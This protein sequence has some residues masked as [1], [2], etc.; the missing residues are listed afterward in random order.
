MGMHHDGLTSTRW[1]AATRGLLVMNHEYTDDG[2]LHPGGM[3]P[4]TAEKVAKSQAAHGISVCEIS[5]SCAG[6]GAPALQQVRAR[7]AT[8]GASPRVTPA[9]GP[10]RPGRRPPADAHRRR[11]RGP[12]RAGHH[13]QL[14]QRHDAL[15]HL[16]VGRRELGQ[17]YFHRPTNPPRTK[18]L[19]HAQERLVPLA[20]H[21][22]RFDTVRHPNEPNR[23]GWIVELDPMPTRHSTPV[24]RTALGRAAHEG[25]WVAVTKDG[26]A[27]VYS[28]EDARFEYIYKFVS[29]DRIAPGR[30]RQDRRAG[31]PRAAGPRHAVRGALRR[32]RHGPLAAAGARPGPADRRQR[33]CR[34]G[35][36]LIKAR[37]ASDAAGRH[38]DG[39]ARVAGHRPGRA[40]STAR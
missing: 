31:Q 25:A 33:L 15:G 30:P 22:E 12:P 24:K 5:R 3:Q 14:R 34:P 23:F 37:Q 29:R 13:R 1:T 32:R 7:R 27:V 9:A 19:G 10:G 18:A 21:D 4:W 26:R 35:E 38:Q 16:P 28:G 39:P 36:V 2:L 40:G 11:P 20:E 17:G 8:H 6:N